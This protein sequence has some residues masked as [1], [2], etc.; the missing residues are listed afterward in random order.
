MK[1]P[2]L[3]LVAAVACIGGISC[4]NSTSRLTSQ[5]EQQF[6]A[7]GI[8]RRAD[9]Q[10]FRYTSDPGGRGE[11]W[12]DRRASIVVTRSSLLIH[13]NEKVG[14]SITP[15]TQR[16]VA[17]QRSGNRVRIRAGKGRSEVIWSFTPPDDAE[18]WT[19]DIRALIAASKR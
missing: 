16:D 6:A 19:R 18:G 17:V 15:R 8:L 14:L 5:Q 2:G 9:D 12:E 11:R 4:D 13:K 10:I 3:L 1:I 7:E